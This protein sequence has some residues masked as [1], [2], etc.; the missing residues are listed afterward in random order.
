M[1]DSGGASS[2]EEGSAPFCL[3]LL[4]VGVEP[5]A[6]SFVHADQVGAGAWRPHQIY[7]GAHHLAQKK[8]M[9]DG[10]TMRKARGTAPAQRRR[11]QDA[12]IIA[13]W[14]SFYTGHAGVSTIISSLIWDIH[15]VEET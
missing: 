9:V 6:A 10:S 1:N 12:E 4:L 15:D 7:T 2:S 5:L 11:L 3:K 14:L 13:C 8:F